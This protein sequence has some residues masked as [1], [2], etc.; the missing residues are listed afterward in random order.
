MVDAT[1]NLAKCS[2]PL[3]TMTGWSI[4]FLVVLRI[5]IG[6]HFF[7]EGLWKLQQNEWRATG[8]LVASSGPLRPVFRWMV[9]DVDGLEALDKDKAAELMH[10]RMDERRDLAIEHYGLTE[11][12]QEIYKEFVERK[13]HGLRDELH[14]TA[15]FLNP[16]FQRALKD[17]R[18]RVA[19]GQPADR[20]T[21]LAFLTP[22]FQDLDKTVRSICTDEQKEAGDPPPMPSIVPAKMAASDEPD[23][24]H[25]LTLDYLTRQRPEH[26]D[27]F[28]PAYPLDARYS[29]LKKHYGL[30]EEQHQSSYGW[31]Y[32]EQ[33]K[34]GGKRDVN[35]VDAIWADPDFQKQVADYRE[36]LDDLEKIEEDPEPDYNLERM[37]YDYGKKARMRADIR[38]RWEKPLNDLDPRK[39]ELFG[40]VMGIDKTSDGDRFRLTEQQLQAG[41]LPGEGSPT[42][43][44]DWSNKI[45]LTLVG[46]CLMVGLLTRLSALGGVALLMLYYFAMPPWP[47]LPESPMA[48]GHYL[49]VNKNLI[50]A[51]ALLMIATSRAGRWAGLDAYLCA[52]GRSKAAKIEPTPARVPPGRL[53]ATPTAGKP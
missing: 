16:E 24:L 33:K 52:G 50:E 30:T 38:V 44:I 3:R 41:P 27:Q 28:D 34:I 1:P 22:V 39:I 35:N 13:K 21:V 11:E 5:M 12:Q 51:V 53:G 10:E 25:W 46:A 37:T 4:V 32:R 9:P 47:G 48:E 23:D 42:W 19:R 26:V 6:W 45:G 14:A 7:Y 36:F 40:E 2:S 8:Y 17:Y 31:R 15:V 49:V 18:V 43:F 20:E 29:T